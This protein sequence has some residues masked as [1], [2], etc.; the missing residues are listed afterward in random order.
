MNGLGLGV[1][2]LSVCRVSKKEH[3]GSFLQAR[4]SRVAVEQSG[5]DSNEAVDD[6]GNKNENCSRLIQTRHY[7]LQ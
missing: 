5:N 2:G 3:T 1:Q 7:T 4:V 6:D